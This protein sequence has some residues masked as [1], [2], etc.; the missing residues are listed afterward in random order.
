MLRVES[1]TRKPL[2]L[3]WLVEAD[4]TMSERPDT[5]PRGLR[6]CVLP[7]LLRGLRLQQAALALPASDL[8]EVR[9]GPDGC[10]CCAI[11]YPYSRIGCPWPGIGAQC[12]PS[13]CLCSQAECLDPRA[14]TDQGG[15]K[16]ERNANLPVQLSLTSPCIIRMR[17]REFL[18]TK[19]L[20]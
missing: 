20:Q 4:S 17:A 3:R 12:P 16:A 6:S 19:I 14:S 8:T 1:C 18:Q 9:P 7:T 13:A 2:P 10:P 5:R 15:A 11:D